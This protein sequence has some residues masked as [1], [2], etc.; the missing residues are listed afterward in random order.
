MRTCAVCAGPAQ[1]LGTLGKATHYRC[2]NCGATLTEE[3]NAM[4][5]PSITPDRVEEL[6]R[7]S[8]MDEERVGICRAC[9]EEQYDV[10]PD[11]EGYRCHECEAFAVTGVE[12]LAMEVL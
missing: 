10:E 9:G 11:A 12:V 6:L 8:V 4:L 7:A 2:R 5:H 3:E 1:L